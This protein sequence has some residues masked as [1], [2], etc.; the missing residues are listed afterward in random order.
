MAAADPVRRHATRSGA[1]QQ[2]ITHKAIKAFSVIPLNPVCA[3]LEDMKVRVG[4]G[5]HQEQRALKG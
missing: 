4:Q 2:E 3:I 1:L 5:V